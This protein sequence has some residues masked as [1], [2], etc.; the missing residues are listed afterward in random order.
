VQSGLLAHEA[1]LLVN[2]RSAVRSRS[3]APRSDEV[4]PSV[5][6]GSWNERYRL[7][8]LAALQCTLRTVTTDPPAPSGSRKLIG[9]EHSRDPGHVGTEGHLVQ[10]SEWPV[11]TA[12]R[13]IFS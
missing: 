7:L 13:V 1:V 3:P 6:L 10:S 9:R 12:S 8:C 2:G 5:C 4:E 11:I